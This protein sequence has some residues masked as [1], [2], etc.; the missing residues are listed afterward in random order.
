MNIHIDKKMFDF[1]MS[2]PNNIQSKIGSSLYNLSDDKSDVDYLI[3]YQPFINQIINPFINHHQYQYKDVENNIDYNF[4]DSITF[5][6][7]LV[8]GDSTINFELIHTENFDNTYLEV[9]WTYNDYFRTYNIV[10]AY[11]GFADRDLRHLHKRATEHDR[12]RGILHIKRSIL[13]A[14]S[15]LSNTFALVNQELIDFKS[16]LYNPK[17]SFGMG[18][19][20]ELRGE[21]KLKRENLNKLLESN[22]IDRYLNPNIQE[23]IVEELINKIQT[24]TNS[25]DLFELYKANEQPEIKYN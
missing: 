9:L 10:K 19:I 14:D 15:I 2:Q 21:L 11:L 16:K 22:E 7:N 18:D 25:L 5:I 24:N 3:I 13:F 23:I 17:F 20:I 12:K 4:I 1:L 6:K 8:N